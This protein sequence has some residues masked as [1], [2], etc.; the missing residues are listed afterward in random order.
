MWAEGKI[1]NGQEEKKEKEE[2]EKKEICSSQTR[3]DP[4]A[5][6]KNNW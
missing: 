5:S 4:V 3:C 1:C 6:G 2:E